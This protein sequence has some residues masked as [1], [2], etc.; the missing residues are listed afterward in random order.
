MHE[1]H[2][3]TLRAT[4]RLQLHA[5]FTL[6]DATAVVPYLD[7]LGISHLY[8]SP[9]LAARTGSRHGYDAID[10]RRI[11]PE[12]G[13]EDDLKTLSTA[14]HERGM[15]LLVDIVPNH[16][17]AG[18]ENPYWEDVLSHGERSRY[19]RW[20]DIDW[21][22]HPDRRVVLPILRDELD[23]VIAH[24]ELRIEVKERGAR[25]IHFDTSVPISPDA[26]PE[27]LQLA[28]WD[29]AAAGEA[30]RL[31]AG[32]DG[33]GRLR[34]L[35]D[36]QHYRLVAWRRGAREINYRRFFDVNDLVAVR[37][38]N[39][40]VFAETHELLLRLVG[41]GVIDALRVDHIDG[42]RDP[43]AY[44]ARLR[45]A[46]DQRRSGGVP[47]V[48]E[49]ILMT[50]ERL[51]DTWPVDGT[52]GYERLNDIEDLFVHPEGFASIERRYLT[53]RRSPELT[54]ESTVRADKRVELD[55]A[56]AA[57]VTRL[58]RLLDELFKAQGSAAT[59]EQI[60]HGIEEFTAAFPLYRSYID[61]SGSVHPDDERILKALA[62]R[63][64]GDNPTVANT[65]AAVALSPPAH[66]P[67]SPPAHQ[68]A[69]EFIARLQQLTGP[70]MAKGMED[71]AH[72]AYVPLVS[73]NEVGGAPNRP[74]AA[75]VENFHDANAG[76]VAHRPRSL[77][78]TS[79]HDT[80]RSGD[81][82]ARIT[83]LSE[84]PDEWHRSVARWRNLNRRHRRIVRGRIV[85]DPNAELFLY[86]TLVGIWPAP[87]AGR[88]ADDVPDR[89]WRA[90][91]L[92]RLQQY[93]LK[94]VREAK[95]RTSWTEPDFAYES[96]L[97]DFLT[98]VFESPEDDPFLPDVA[99]LVSRVGPIAQWSS[100]S[101]VL[102][103]L[104][105]PG[106]PDIYQGDE[107][108]N[109]A[110]VDPDNRRPV[111]YTA[112]RSSLGSVPA[113][114]ASVN[115]TIALDDASS[116]MVVTSRALAARRAYERLFTMGDYR[117]LAATGPRSA[118]VVAFARSADGEHAVVV[119]P[120]LVGDLLG[121]PV[122]DRWA[123]TVVDLPTDIGRV[124]LRCAITGRTAVVRDDNLILAETSPDMAFGLF[125]SVA[126][127][128]AKG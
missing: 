71:T 5:G 51:R 27:S 47:I 37:V 122:P 81:T 30:E 120:R 32:R 94:A 106:T 90:T 66:H 55:R 124:Q 72:Y 109:Y 63:G 111:D 115:A 24:G 100:L 1:S 38:E 69:T 19:A 70:A 99:R 110:L 50:G 79:T 6:R 52:T 54:F 13:T 22:M 17:A 7:D 34:A 89:Q 112:R 16:M 25:L 97:A 128:E 84:V 98:A 78:A 48:V 82:R 36:T 39:P 85:P 116:K 58:A 104:T 93:M 107:L 126:L 123:G 114:S 127:S 76:Y 2:A 83:A 67:T 28:Q 102:L 121:Q 77:V 105:I 119:A 35:L 44:L 92:A 21:R 10:P 26:E 3:P 11:N 45:G 41:E 73:R 12:L 42:L 61:A 103:H 75:A 125:L 68:L 33:E 117:S 15:G 64:P 9:I 101:R 59:R 74:L 29:P 43:A 95:L 31:F 113:F 62:A 46:T 18:M 20:F 87:R 91:A 4:Y 96:A 53:L 14:L 23:A 56:F 57:D 118:N 86:Q 108:W 80:K 60:Y 88:R 40:E 8:A 49:K 65:I